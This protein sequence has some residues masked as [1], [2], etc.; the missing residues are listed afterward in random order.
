MNKDS[1]IL[2]TFISIFDESNTLASNGIET[3]QIIEL[4][5][6]IAAAK[7]VFHLIILENAIAAIQVGAATSKNTHIA[8]SGRKV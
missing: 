5:M 2:T 4:R 3:T 1:N 8:R 6:V 7:L